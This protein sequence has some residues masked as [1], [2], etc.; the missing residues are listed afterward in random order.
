[1]M[2]RDSG[3]FF[4]AV[5]EI[6]D[7]DLPD[8]QHLYQTLEKGDTDLERKGQPPSLFSR[9]EHISNYERISGEIRKCFGCLMI[10]LLHFF[11]LLLEEICSLAY[12]FLDR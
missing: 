2:P 8:L 5:P 10:A 4:H 7:A 9:P 11:L 12:N 3:H 6:D 1:M